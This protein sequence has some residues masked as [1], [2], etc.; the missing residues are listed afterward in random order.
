MATL[1]FLLE[2]DIQLIV[3][4]STADVLRNIQFTKLALIF[5]IRN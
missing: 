3:Q 5:F 2:G 1:S 4:N